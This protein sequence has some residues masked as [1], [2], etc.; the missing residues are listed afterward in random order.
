MMGRSGKSCIQSTVLFA[1]VAFTSGFAAE[2]G[3]PSP[4]PRVQESAA[5]ETLSGF[6]ANRGQWPR[7]V[8]FFAR[9]GSVEATLTREALVFRPAP[10]D[11][12][13][14]RPWPSPLM[15]WL[16]R[17]ADPV[18]EDAVPT[19]HHFLLGSGRT[20]H[21]PGF[22]RVVYRDV[23]PGIDLVV[24]KDGGGAAFAYDVH[25]APGARLEDL[26]LEIEGAVG[27]EPV[28][29]RV[30]AM[31]TA[32]GRV[33]QRIGA[34]WQEAD[35]GVR[36]PVAAEFR[37]IETSSEALRFG[38]AVS[39][40]DPTRALVVDPTLEWATYVGGPGVLER[41]AVDSL[42]AVFLA[43]RGSVGSPTTPGAI[44]PAPNGG[45][46]AWFGKLSPDGTKLEWGTYLGGSGTEIDFGIAVAPDGGIVVGGRTWSADFPTTLGCLQ[47]VFVGVT[48]KN[49]LFAAKLTPD[50][51]SLVWSTYY[52]GPDYEGGEF[53]LEVFPS[54]DVLLTA[55]PYTANPPS[56]PGAFDT[57]FDPGDN[58][59]ARI[60]ADGSQLL[61]QTYF[62]VSRILD[63]EIDED[64]N[65]CFAGDVALADGDGPLPATPGAFKTAA[66]IETGVEGFVAKMNGMG[67]HLLWATYLGGDE[68]YDTVWGLA[69]DAAGAVYAAGQTDSDDFPTTPGV[70]AEVDGGA[71]G[72]VTKLLPNG[73][74]LAWSTY[75]GTTCC[76]GG[77]ALWDIAVDSAGN[78]H[79]TGSAN[80]PALPV[81]PDAFQPTYTGPFPSG[82]VFLTKF[83]AFGEALIYSTWF[84]G[85]STDDFSKIALDPIPQHPIIALRSTSVDIPVTPGAYDTTNEGSTET[86]VAKFDLPL[87]PWKVMA[88]GKAGGADIPNLAGDGG[89]TPGSQA[90]LS[91]RG[92]APTATTLLF[93]GFTTIDAPALGGTFVPSPDIVVALATDASGGIDL[94]FIWPNAPPGIDLYLQ[95]WIT[96][97]GALFGWSATNAIQLTSQ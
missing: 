72:F 20:S 9:A 26:T 81:T 28:S 34:S 7:D 8:L 44:Q 80:E 89:L 75:F 6:V 57:S 41:M 67:T 31:E 71:R 61:F 19:Q 86:V 45:P 42:G 51:S 77:S 83:D 27:L 38:F 36:E 5:I 22:G 63:I 10:P 68:G 66:G 2:D 55:A 35:T 16:P 97:P 11:P 53:G 60:S 4:R 94:P 96:D 50:G 52:G 30:L 91:I 92:A 59:L 84:A 48:G 54:G 74:G 1:T 12:G 58:L 62:S 78:A 95:A 32:A 29:A 23:A 40:R 43:G 25:V 85:T 87:L 21:V 79:V 13:S 15:L 24:R 37:L 14:G 49:D 18:G 47:P 90:R 64:E 73:C 33:E 93:A 56:T 46:E 88:G 76:G 3:A 17:P 70:F 39:D 69:I 82:D 65:I